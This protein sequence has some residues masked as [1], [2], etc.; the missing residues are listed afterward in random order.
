VSSHVRP[1]L[2]RPGARFA[3]AGD[4]LCCTDL[5]AL[6]PLSRSEARSLRVLVP[7]SVQFH[8]D[9]EAPCMRPG[10]DGA[11]AQLGPKGC[12]IHARFGADEKP[13]GCTRFPYGLVA[14]P[15]GGRVTTESRCPC[16]T[17]GKRPP[18]DLADAERSLVDQ[19]GRLETDARAP[20]RVPMT[21]RSRLPFAR[22]AVLEASML[23]RLAAGERIERVLAAKPFPK[24]ARS[25][26]PRLATELLEVADQTRGGQALAWVVDAMLAQSAGFGAPTR[27]RPWR[28]AFERG[29]ARASRAESADAVLADWVADE[30]WMM[31]W[32]TWDTR[33][34]VA[35]AEL[36]T[37]VACARAIVTRLQRA[38][39][40]P[41]QAAAEAIMACELAACCEAWEGVVDAI[42][43]DPSP[44]DALS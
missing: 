29:A 26:W 17:L 34:D 25:S 33:F 19:S 4:G 30:L 21:R 23:A 36:A 14:T 40:R 11:C 44:A 1:L 24:L 18:L 16:R 35:R 31:R 3:C 8:E 43:T 22:Y 37:R 15:A 7:R 5:H 28:D 27:P 12:G 38:G 13:V 6:G 39:V 9:I 41:D 42:A 32:L 10:A 20:L 2:S